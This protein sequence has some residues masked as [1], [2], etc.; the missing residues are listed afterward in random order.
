LI[1]PHHDQNIDL[2]ILKNST[3]MCQHHYPHNSKRR[4]K[5]KKRR[6]SRAQEQ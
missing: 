3:I 5:D 2:V 4:Q 6:I 1:G